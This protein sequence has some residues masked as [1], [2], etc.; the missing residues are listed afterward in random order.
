MGDLGVCCHY[1]GQQENTQKDLD[2]GHILKR[3]SLASAFPSRVIWKWSPLQGTNKTKPNKGSLMSP[4]TAGEVKRASP[5]VLTVS[6]P[7]CG[8]SAVRN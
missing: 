7:N 6:P 8:N 3:S 2:S 1:L 5:K 4:V